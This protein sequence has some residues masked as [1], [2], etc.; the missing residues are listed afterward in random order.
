MSGR[1]DTDDLRGSDEDRDALGGTVG[2][3]IT[4]G[5][6]QDGGPHEPGTEDDDTPATGGVSTTPATPSA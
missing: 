1:D 2:A 5:A 6:L 3:G 4:E